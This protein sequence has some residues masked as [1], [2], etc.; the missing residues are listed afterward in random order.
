VL[1]GIL[2]GQGT[3]IGR[4]Y[5][6]LLFFLTTPLVV[7]TCDKWGML[8]VTGIC[9]GWFS[10]FD[11]HPWPASAEVAALGADTIKLLYL[12]VLLSGSVICLLPC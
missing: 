2:G 8:L 1:A 10:L 3:E 11:L 12:N 9:I 4:H 6:F 7:P 5:Y